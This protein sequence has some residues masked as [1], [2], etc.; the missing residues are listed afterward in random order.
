MAGPPTIHHKVGDTFRAACIYR[1]ANGAAV[2]LRTAGIT[3]ASAVKAKGG[4]VWPLTFSAGDNAAAQGMFELSGETSS[5]TPG[6]LAWDIQFTNARGISSTETMFI[7]VA[8]D[9]TP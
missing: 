8:P 4:T 9:V 2:D 6:Q 1:D 3:I 5:W 7:V